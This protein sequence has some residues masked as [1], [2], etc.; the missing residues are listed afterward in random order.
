MDCTWWNMGSCY[1]FLKIKK[2]TSKY[3]PFL[4]ITL[5]AML[6]LKV[7]NCYYLKDFAYQRINTEKNTNVR[8]STGK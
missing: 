6:S 1:K 5:L 3:A 7:I 2:T 4:S 8:I